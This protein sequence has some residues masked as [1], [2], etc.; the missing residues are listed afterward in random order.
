[1]TEAPPLLGTRRGREEEAADVGS[2]SSIPGT[3]LGAVL[4]APGSG[5]RFIPRLLRTAEFPGRTL[6]TTLGSSQ[7]EFWVSRW[8]WG[9]ACGTGG[10]G[11]VR[12]AAGHP[13]VGGALL[14]SKA[15][16]VLRGER[17]LCPSP[18]RL[19]WDRPSKSLQ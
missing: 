8:G 16:L 2:L 7:R 6:P 14:V 19:Y 17:C 9:H 18:F 4:A 3:F 13:A 11:K 1:M 12:G 15:N 5:T 10:G